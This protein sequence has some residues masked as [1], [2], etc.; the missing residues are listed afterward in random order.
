MCMLWLIRKK[1]NHA[2]VLFNSNRYFANRI[3]LN[4][5]SRKINSLFSIAMSSFNVIWNFLQCYNRSMFLRALCIYLRLSPDFLKRA[6]ECLNDL[7]LH[8]LWLVYSH[9]WQIT[10][11]LKKNSSISRFF[12]FS[13][14]SFFNESKE[15][16]WWHILYVILI[17]IFCILIYFNTH[18]TSHICCYCTL[19]NT[20]EL[21]NE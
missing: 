11:K 20:Q 4:R 18:I 19:K 5:I 2:V 15:K 21:A 12:F 1:A 9:Y 3:I 10:I 6:K 8:F 14:K 7:S 13:F 17:Y 16:K